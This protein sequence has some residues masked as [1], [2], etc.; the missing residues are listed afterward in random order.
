MDTASRPNAQGYI[1]WPSFLSTPA[2]M[3]R[4]A[5]TAALT[6]FIGGILVLLGL[7]TRPAALGILC[8]LVTA[9]WL[10]QIGP[11][12]G[13]AGSFM[14]FLPD[15]AMADPTAWNS[16]NSGWL[17][18][19]WE[20]TLGCVALG[21]VLSGPGRVSMDSLIFRRG[22]EDAPKKFERP[23]EQPPKRPV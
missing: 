16:S 22:D 11:S 21:L 6:Q 13:A 8:T 10:T 18:M 3:E 15:P 14:G 4:M 9:L 19:L 23:V 7:L 1:L 12:I 2:W 17:M 5:W 20:F